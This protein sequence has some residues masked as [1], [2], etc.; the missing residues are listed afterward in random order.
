MIRVAVVGSG[1][2]LGTEVVAALEQSAGYSP[3]PLPHS[4]IDCTQAES[5][6]E[7]LRSVD[8]AIVVN[9]A[10]YV[11]VDQCED[12]AEDAVRVNALGALH[13]A[14]TCAEL[15][16]LCTYVSTDY[17]FDGEKD[18]PYGEIDS[19]RPVN[20][21]GAS[22]L[23]GEYFVRQTAPDWLIVRTASLFGRVGARAK[24][25]NFVETI[26]QRARAS[27]PL[28]VVNDIRMSPTYARDLAEALVT[29][30]KQRATGIVH[31]TNN[32]ACTWYEFAALILAQ[33]RLHVELA[34]V[35][36]DQY[37]FRAARPRNSVLTST[38]IPP[39]LPSPLRPWQ[40]A[41]AAYLQDRGY[42]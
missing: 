37:P 26:V 3:V 36:A 2:Q 33:S 25:G 13:V 28:R 39:L 35:S 29:L 41:V 42:A 31:L 38:R 1:G 15:K 4:Q 23:L 8:P 22:K 11:H 20:V 40:N 14:R 30:L 32:G 19:P 34:A 24:Q 21:Y 6:R 9:C 16:A 7:V 18:G 27:F 12:R 5:V 10:A 17:V